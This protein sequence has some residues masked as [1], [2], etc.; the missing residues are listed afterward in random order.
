MLCASCAP[1]DLVTSLSSGIDTVVPMNNDPQAYRQ[2]G[3]P[4]LWTQVSDLHLG[5]IGTQWWLTK[6]S[7]KS[8][9]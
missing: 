6:I 8:E 1:T 4:T 5:E 2:L 7:A 3:S 9:F